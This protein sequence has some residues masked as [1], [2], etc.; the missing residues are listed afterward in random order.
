MY[1]EVT[2]KTEEKI[3]AWSKRL[4]EFILEKVTALRVFRLSRWQSKEGRMMIAVFACIR[5][6]VPV[7]LP[8]CMEQV[9]K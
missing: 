4:A 8:D 6:E 3:G 1:F 2:V 7:V 5:T 9:G